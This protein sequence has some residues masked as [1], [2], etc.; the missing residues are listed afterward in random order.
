MNLGLNQEQEYIVIGRNRIPFYKEYSGRAKDVMP[1]ILADGRILL[2]I[3]E[4][5]QRRIDVKTAEESVKGYW[6]DNSFFTRDAVVC[7]GSKFKINLDSDYLIGLN[8]ES[9]LKDR[10]LHISDRDYESLKR[11]EFSREEVKEYLGIYPN[12]MVRTSPILQILA[13][14]QELLNE[15]AS[16]IISEKKARRHL[17]F[18]IGFFLLPSPEQIFSDVRPLCVRGLD[19][20]AN[21]DCLDDLGFESGKIV[22]GIIPELLEILRA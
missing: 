12:N 22:A 5:M 21:I 8:S 1:L 4:V 16:N 2:S 17:D 10:L 18:A 20:G 19:F 13:R 14:K 11:K 3:A 9:E 15:Y 7:R 6:L